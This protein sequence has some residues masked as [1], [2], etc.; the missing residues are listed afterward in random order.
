MS[1]PAARSVHSVEGEPGGAR[2]SRDPAGGSVVRES[3]P[4]AAPGG[5][6]ESRTGRKRRGASRLPAAG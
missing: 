5:P 6:A 2:Q 3:R 4:I 1:A